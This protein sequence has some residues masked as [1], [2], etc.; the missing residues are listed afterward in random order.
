MTYR[1]QGV[2]IAQKNIGY[3]KDYTTNTADITVEYTR[4]FDN[5]AISTYFFGGEEVIFSGS[6]VENR[7]QCEIL[8]D[9]FGLPTDFKSSLTFSPRIQNVIVDFDFYWRFNWCNRNFDLRINMPFVHSKWALNPCEI[10]S[11]PGTIDYPAGYMGPDLITRSELNNSALQALS[12]QRAVGDV[13]FPMQY[14]RIG[15]GSITANKIADIYVALGYNVPCTRLKALHVDLNVSIPTGTVPN[16]R[17]LFAPQIGNGRHWALGASISLQYDFFS[18]DSKC[19]YQV[20]AYFDGLIQHLFKSTQKRSYDFCQNGPGSRYTLL[21]DMAAN[22]AGTLGFTPG[23]PPSNG[24][25]G[26][27]YITRLLYAIDVTTFDSKIKI[28]AQADIDAKIAFKYKNASVTLGYN[29][30]VRSAEK[31]VSRECLQHHYYG[32][33]GDAQ[34]YGFFDIGGMGV[35]P[36]IHIPINATQSGSTLR[37]PQGNGNTVDNFVNNNADNAAFLYN[38]V[39][40]LQQ[41]DLNSLVNTGITS[42]AQ[43]K[44]SNMAVLVTDDDI[45]NCSGLSPRA[46]TNKIF[47]SIEYDFRVCNKESYILL[48]AEA[49]FAS[50]VDCVKTTVSQWGIWLKGGITY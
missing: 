15:C 29:L 46:L 10:V 1:S 14:G 5:Q 25:A 22:F 32:I 43:V 40:P 41:T 27:I 19:D 12:G 23:F 2:N 33:K 35:P 26:N 49:E 38:V 30:W 11:N 45:N 47:G 42:R 16:G 3:L 17:C 21:E 20:T 44:G 50:K 34:V 48:G 39:F 24:P 18:P 7:G 31:L 28:N 4:S 37:K 13:T 8:A 6:R 9:Y 36:T